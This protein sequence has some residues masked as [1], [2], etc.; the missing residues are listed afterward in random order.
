L[1]TSEKERLHAA[2]AFCE[3]LSATFGVLTVV[4]STGNIMTRR[5]SSWQRPQFEGNGRGR[6]TN[7]GARDC[8]ATGRPR[9]TPAT[10][11]RS[12]P[13]RRQSA[14]ARVTGQAGDRRAHLSPARSNHRETMPVPPT[15]CAWRPVGSATPPSYGR[16]GRLS[17]GAQCHVRRFPGERVGVT[18]QHVGGR[19]RAEVR[20]A[21]LIRTKGRA[22]SGRPRCRNN[23]PVVR[24]E[25]G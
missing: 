13:H 2:Q 21:T 9:P 19:D 5:F 10:P 4:E 16:P 17:L 11:S 15:R 25:P 23:V 12:P 1:P 14:R 3:Q 20:P 22:Q 7:H 18:W 6:A 8:N 24:A